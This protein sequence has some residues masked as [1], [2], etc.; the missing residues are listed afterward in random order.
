MF[1]PGLR[2]W[3]IS[4]NATQAVMFTRLLLIAEAGR[5][6]DPLGSVNVPGDIYTPDGGVDGQTDLSPGAMEP[7]PSGPCSWQVKASAAFSIPRELAKD[8][9][10]ADISAGRDYVIVCTKELIGGAR[11][12][13]QAVLSAGVAEIDPNRTGT[14][15]TIEDL[16]RMARIHPAVPA[17]MDGPQP[18]GMRLEVWA[19]PL[20]VDE[21]PYQHD[22]GR[23]EKIELIRAFAE[24]TEGHYLHVFG[25]SGVGKSR[26]V[27]EA[28]NV[29]GIR[30][31]VAAHFEYS[32]DA[33]RALLLA[34]ATDETRGIVV[35]DEVE[36][37]DAERLRTAAA[38]ASGRIRLITIGDRQSRVVG[39]D[40]ASL[41]IQPLGEGAVQELVKRVGGISDEDAGYV[42]HLSDGY[43]KLAVLLAHEIRD[44]TERGP[45]LNLI[46]GHHINR[47]LEEMLPDEDARRDLA[48]LALVNRLGF[49]GDLEAEAKALCEAFELPYQAFRVRVTRETGR[50]VA[51]SGRYRRVSPQAFAVWLAEGLIESDPDEFVERLGRLP[52]PL[53]QS[54]ELQL[55]E[56]GGTESFDRVLREVVVRR[57]ATF[58]G[59]LDVTAADAHLLHAIAYA[60][61]D[62]AAAE[63]LRLT[64]ATRADQIK[65]FGGEPRRSLVWALQHL[66]WFS[67]S[68]PAAADAL[69][70]LA[71]FETETW[72]NNATGVLVE[73]FQMRLGGTEV[74]LRDRFEWLGRNAGR[75]GEGSLY[76]AVKAVRQALEPSETRTGG[77]RGARLQPVEWRPS[78][79]EE[80]VGLYQEA[81]N[82][83][84]AWGH[85]N[86]WLRPEVAKA[87]SRASWTLVRSGCTTQFI[88]AVESIEW[89][90][91]ERSEL[92]T[93][94]RRELSFNRGLAEGD[95][96]L[97]STLAATLEG[98]TSSTRLETL[99]ATEVWELDE[100]RGAQGPPA[101]LEE[102]ATELAGLTPADISEQIVGLP[103]R[104]DSTTFALF[105]ILGQRYPD[106]DPLADDR[107]LAPVARVGYLSG[108]GER[109]R[110]RAVGLVERWRTNPEDAG[111]VPWAVASI[112]A[113]PVL[114]AAAIDV[115]RQGRALLGDL[116][117]L[118]YGRWVAALP[119]DAIRDLVVLYLDHQMEPFDVESIVAMLDSWLEENSD[120]SDDLRSL[121][122]RLFA[123]AAVEDGRGVL[124]YGRNRLAD[125]LRLSAEERLPPTLRALQVSGYPANEDVS[126]LSRMASETPEYV[127]PEVVRFVTTPDPR[128]IL[129]QDSHLLSV[130]ARATSDEL[131]LENLL[132]LDTDSL[133]RALRHIDFTAETLDP[134]VV[135]LLTGREDDSEIQRE[136][137]VRYV[138]PGEVVVGPYSRRIDERLAQALR[139][140]AEH[141]SPVVREWATNVAAALEGMLPGERLREAESGI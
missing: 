76:I 126:A 80:V 117:R 115:V 129:L 56:L 132:F 119:E 140:Q 85:E 73:S 113:E 133:V 66:L 48:H 74:S 37:G 33:R 77:W 98:A 7:F 78:G 71:V 32:D 3:L 84:I 75:Y 11:A 4:L 65:A 52:Y 59:L 20:S 131:V 141:S 100:S 91:E 2:A 21:F 105:R 55:Q 81:L 109:D 62:L 29:T 22:P 23:A 104:K 139:I 6:K 14:M 138:F 35:I 135:G 134:I 127:V 67:L 95:R 42:A 88:A 107:R 128:Q 93:G 51:T 114:V 19:R 123:L 28:L 69:L 1:G 112:D 124:T 34:A 130:L 27:Y 43:P 49:D 121:G 60:S 70:A 136:A 87:L 92:R 79:Y 16:E 96:E 120:I 30:E 102:V 45:L 108:L 86:E 116:H 90:A 54:F 5:L 64:E 61:P 13:Q 58:L 24:G 8:G 63:I 36:P 106:L 39:A 97:L 17:L 44:A 12:R 57:T 122:S 31:R 125:R 110:S 9:V 38:S 72:A 137:L 118:R 111:L 83:L 47:L 89:A 99:L 46:R 18:L 103:S 25:D 26:G 82:M 40:A 50:F 41:E 68:Y 53:Y 10:R 94:I 15:V 101:V